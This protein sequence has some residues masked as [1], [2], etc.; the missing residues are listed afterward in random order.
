M[1]VCMIATVAVKDCPMHM[2]V[3]ATIAVKILDSK[4]IAITLQELCMRVWVCMYD[5]Y[6]SRQRLSYAHVCVIATVAVKILDSKGIAITLQ[7][8]CMH[9]CVYV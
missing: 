8:L 7:D 5:S 4:R 3:I 6:S 1:C 9:V 2:C